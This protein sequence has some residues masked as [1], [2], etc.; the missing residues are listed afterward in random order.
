MCGSVSHQGQPPL[1][2]TQLCR[3][4]TRAWRGMGWRVKEKYSALLLPRY[5]TTTCS[6]LRAHHRCGTRGD[7]TCQADHTGIWEEPK[8]CGQVTYSA[9]ENLPFPNA[10]WRER[11]KISNNSK[12]ILGELV[13]L[14]LSCVK[15]HLCLTLTAPLSHLSSSIPLFLSSHAL[16]FKLPLWLIQ[17]LM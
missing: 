11:V 7:C 1:L 16:F 2:L 4:E 15:G 13:L 10:S 12:G 5:A 6:P 17:K 3:H 8:Q 9:S 14:L